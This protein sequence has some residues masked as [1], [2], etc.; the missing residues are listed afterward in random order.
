MSERMICKP[1][2]FGGFCR[3]CRKARSLSANPLSPVIS[4]DA[5]NLCDTLGSLFTASFT[6]DRTIGLLIHR[7][8]LIE[9]FAIAATRLVHDAIVKVPARSA[10]A[11]FRF[12]ASLH[13]REQYRVACSAP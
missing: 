8:A 2:Q 10:E 3:S 4:L 12:N 5:A 9:I 7:A 1:Q 13:G 11:D 6:N